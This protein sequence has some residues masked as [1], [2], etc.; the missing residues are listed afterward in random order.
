MKKSA[1]P[2]L[3]LSL[4]VV[5]IILAAC[6]QS[7]KSPEIT[8]NTLAA[9]DL[10]LTFSGDGLID[11]SLQAGDDRA[12]AVAIQADGKAVLAGTTGAG[13]YGVTRYKADGS[14]LDLSFDA[15]GIRV[16]DMGSATDT[17]TAMTLQSNGKIVVVG[18]VAGGFGKDV[19]IMRL[20]SNGTLDNTFSGDGK[21]FYDF[22]HFK[23]DFVTGV[24]MQGNKIVVSGYVQEDSGSSSTAFVVMRLN[25][26]GTPDLSFNASGVKLIS[27]SADGFFSAKANSLS[28][29]NNKIVVVGRAEFNDNNWYFGVARLNN[30]GTLDNS[31][32]GNGLTAFNFSDLIGPCNVGFENVAFGVSVNPGLFLAGQ[33][34][35]FVVVGRT[36]ACGSS[37]AAVARLKTNGDLDTTFSSDGKRVIGDANFENARAVRTSGGFPMPG[38][39]VSPM[40]ITIAGSREGGIATDFQV[41]RLNW[42]GTSDLGFSGDGK[43]TTDLNGSDDRAY[44]LALSGGKIY[45]AGETKNGASYEF[46]VARYKAN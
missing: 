37:D 28:I 39:S 1:N 23:D 10:D 18:E 21:G 8:L 34:I 19:G 13:N 31:F 11:S 4:S 22:N 40:K 2:F 15:D 17:A 32:S 42:N 45:V 7:P 9:G 14:G 29:I 12:R 20:N 35:G 46:A 5:M 36:N 3:A 26:N 25:S 30:N 43:L 33:D 27:F 6:G 44:A 38:P 16:V 41:F 24:V